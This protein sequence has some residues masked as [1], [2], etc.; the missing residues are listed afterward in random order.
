[1]DCSGSVAVFNDLR[2]HQRTQRSGLPVW[3]VYQPDVAS[4]VLVLD[5]GVAVSGHRSPW[6]GADFVGAN[7]SSAEV[8]AFWRQVRDDAA[9]HGADRL[10]V[11]LRPDRYGPAQRLSTYAL[12]HLGLAVEAS[13]LNHVIDLQT[14]PTVAAYHQRIGAKGRNMIRSA[15][16][17]GVT[18]G[19]ALDEDDWRRGFAVLCANKAAKGRSMAYDLDHLLDVRDR[20][21]PSVRMLVSR[22]G[23]SIVAA[24]VT[25]RVAPDV[26]LVTA[27]GDAQHELA[28]S[29]M[30]QLAD[31]MVRRAVEESVR[32]IDL[33]SSTDRNGVPN[34]GLARFKE[35]VG[36][37]AHFRL[38]VIGATREHP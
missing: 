26:E 19:P 27:W 15:E 4:A 21:A 16:R 32:L 24:A 29:P 1:M 23:A 35:S 8:L 13:W 36:A 10:R 25:Y 9:G 5:G 6:G 12:L 7:P 20:F 33:G 37:D 34:F 17:L 31:A 2:Y 11:R 18:V 22:A 3:A 14:T 28:R 30:N 38:D